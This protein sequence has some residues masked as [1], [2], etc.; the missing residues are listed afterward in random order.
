MIHEV[1]WAFANERWGLDM[2]GGVLFT[3]VNSIKSLH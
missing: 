3:I 1:L 2:L